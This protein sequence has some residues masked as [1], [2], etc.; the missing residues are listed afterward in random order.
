MD[1]LNEYYPLCPSS[2][3]M[4]SDEDS[5]NNKYIKRL[6]SINEGKKRK[7]IMTLDDFCLKYGDDMWYIWNIIKDY[8]VNSNLLNRLSYSSFCDVCYCNSTQ[9]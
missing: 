9:Y 8:S 3:N 5:E 4:D 1:I 7:I 2:P 6:D